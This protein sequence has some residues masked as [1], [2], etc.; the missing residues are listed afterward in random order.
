M[1]LSSLGVGR[2]AVIVDPENVINESF[3][4][5]NTAE[6]GPVTLRLMGTDGSSYV[7][8]LPYPAQLLPVR[9]PVVPA[10]ARKPI[11]VK[12]ASGG[13][14]PLQETAAEAEQPAAHPDRL[15]HP[16][17]QLDQEIRLSAPPPNPGRR[18]PAHCLEASLALLFFLAAHWLQ[19]P[20]AGI[21]ESRIT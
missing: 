10:K 5:N 15:P 14:A 18:R 21:P 4:N 9:A 16:G 3:K 19:K 13:Q 17:E 7:P 1:T 2:I 12:E 11:I 20:E 6:S 8:N